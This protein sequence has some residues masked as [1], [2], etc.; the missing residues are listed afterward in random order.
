LENEAEQEADEMKRR[1]INDQLRLIAEDSNAARSGYD[2]SVQESR[3]PEQT[4]LALIDDF[5]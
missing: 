2:G 5:V 3:N 4:L 1:L